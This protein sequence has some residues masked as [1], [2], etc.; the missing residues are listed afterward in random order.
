MKGAFWALLVT[1]MSTLPS[2][3]FNPDEVLSDPALEARARGLTSQ[4]RCMVCQNQSIDDS[5]AE[6]A[7]D[8]RVLVRD[9]LT[10]GDSDEAVINYVVSRYGE[11]VLLKPRLSART[12]LLWG[13]PIGLITV[14]A[15]CVFVFSRRRAVMAEGQKLTADEEARIRE[16]LEK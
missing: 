10:Q 12:V 15:I 11:F 7:R 1:I 8:L 3:A 13:A 9:R 4:L 5:N 14:G 16:L 2:F 6:L